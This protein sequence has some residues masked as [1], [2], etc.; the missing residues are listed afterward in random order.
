MNVELLWGRL[1]PVVVHFP[2]AFILLAAAIEMVRIKWDRPGFS[3][4][5][6]LLLVAGALGALVVSATG[7]EFSHDYYPPPSKQW[8]LAWHRWLGLSTTILAGVAAVVAWN[9]KTAATARKI[10]LR[11]TVILLAALVLIVTAHFGALM[12]WGADYFDLINS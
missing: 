6:T 2:I 11:R 4:F 10:W 3:D 7:L 9:F 8:M 1:H 5:V 12:V